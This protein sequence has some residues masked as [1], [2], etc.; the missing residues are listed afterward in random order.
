[1][2][3]R[4]HCL[5]SSNTDRRRKFLRQSQCGARQ[6]E[7]DHLGRTGADQK[8]QP[9]VR[10]P[11]DQLSYDPVQFI[12]GIGE[13]EIPLFHDRRRKSGL[14]EYHHAGRGLNSDVRRCASPLPGRTH[15]D[16][17]CSQTIPVSPQNTS[18]W[19]FSRR[20]GLGATS[21]RSP[22]IRAH[23][24]SCPALRNGGA[25][26][27]ATRSSRRA[28]RSFNTNCVALTKYDAYAASASS[29]CSRGPPIPANNAT[30]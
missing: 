9:D 16:L 2:L 24:H 28:A 30:R 15:P 17:R 10:P 21:A 12:I 22:D 6:I 14:R 19:P 29:I 27:D 1:M 4:F 26:D 3:S 8:Q 20:T 18:R 23:A 13:P 7:L 11:C 5:R 25:A